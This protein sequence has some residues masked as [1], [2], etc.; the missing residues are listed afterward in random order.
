MGEAIALTERSVLFR[1]ADFRMRRA[2]HD[3]AAEPSTFR[4]SLVRAVDGHSKGSSLGEIFHLQRC[5]DSLR[6]SL[7][8]PTPTSLKFCL[9]VQSTR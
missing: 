7:R 4:T 5:Q 9:S 2:A 1:L 3:Y 6:L 8:L